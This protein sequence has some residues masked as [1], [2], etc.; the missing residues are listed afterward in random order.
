MLSPPDLNVSASAS[1]VPA[2]PR[3]CW[4]PSPRTRCW[5]GEP[6]RSAGRRPSSAGRRSASRISRALCGL[7]RSLLLPPP[8]WNS[9]LLT[10]KYQKSPGIRVTFNGNPAGFPVYL[11]PD[12]AQ[13][14]DK[15]GCDCNLFYIV[16]ASDW[17]PRAVTQLLCEL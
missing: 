12:S 14:L 7:R 4:S 13:L 10:R 2:A 9:P 1:S 3:T 17:L 16:V 11:I 6:Q 5:P 8:C 15:V